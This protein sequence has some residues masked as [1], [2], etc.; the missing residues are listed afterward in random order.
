MKPL[1]VEEKEDGE[2]VNV[3]FAIAEAS[4]AELEEFP[5]EDKEAKKKLW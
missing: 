5:F 2:E 1:L 4:K 3:A